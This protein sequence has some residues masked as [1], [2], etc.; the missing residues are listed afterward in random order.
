MR[1]VFLDDSVQTD[2]PRAGLG[3]LV[4]VGAVLVPEHSVKPYAVDLAKIRADLSIPDTEEIKWKPAKKTFLADAGGQVVGAL[5]QRMLQAAIDRDIR[6]AVVIWDRG[7]V[8][9]ERDKVAPEILKYLYER[10]E[11]CL[12][13]HDDL[14]AVIAD[15]PGGGQVQHAKWLAETLPLTERGTVYVKSERVVLPMVIAPS[16]HVPHLALADLVTAATTAAVAG[17]PGGFA[18]V[19]L[20]NQLAHKNVRGLAGGAGI[21]LWPPQLRNLHYWVFGESAYVKLARNAG[22][23]LPYSGWTYASDDGLGNTL[24]AGKG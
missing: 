23:R 4:A 3:E 1:L 13:D 8:P 15:V 20:L 5:R 14:G 6:S 19:P 9:W 16:H 7:N 10:I 11:M 17:R 22:W 12:D 24:G 21:V 18:L 2:P